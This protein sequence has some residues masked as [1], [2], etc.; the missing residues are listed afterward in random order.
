MSNLA[1][2]VQIAVS[3]VGGILGGIFLGYYAE[4][5]L[6]SLLNLNIKPGGI[7]VGVL[8]GVAVGV[9]SVYRIVERQNKLEK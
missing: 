7:I 6:L 8:L 1:L 4:I 3:I 2:G 9:Y 5:G